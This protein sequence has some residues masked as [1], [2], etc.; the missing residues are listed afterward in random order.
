MRVKQVQK[1]NSKVSTT[2]RLPRDL[3]K[4]LDRIA[5]RAGVSRTNYFVALLERD[6]TRQA[7]ATPAPAASEK[8]TDTNIFG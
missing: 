8:T 4:R 6:L 7:D 1:A 5:K 2:M 3:L